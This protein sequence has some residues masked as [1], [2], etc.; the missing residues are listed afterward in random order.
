[1]TPGA[2]L[3]VI[4]WTFPSTVIEG[5]VSA[6]VITRACGWPP[7]PRTTMAE[8]SRASAAPPARTVAAARPAIRR[9]ADV[10][11]A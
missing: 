11:M 3:T 5:Q 10:R 1:M 6:S 2:A 9:C 7:A 4:R 8:V